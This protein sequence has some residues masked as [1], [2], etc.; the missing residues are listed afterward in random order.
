MRDWGKEKIEEAVKG[1]NTGIEKLVKQVEEMAED[2]AKA[3]DKG[4]VKLGM[5]F[6]ASVIAALKEQKTDF[7][8]N[9]LKK[10]ERLNFKVEATLVRKDPAT[11]TTG[12]VDAVGTNSIPFE[13]AS[14]EYGLTRIARRQPWLLQLANVSTTNKMYVQWA[15]QA[16]REGAANEVAEGT[17]KPQIDFDWVEKSAK[18]EKIAAYIKVSKEALDDLDGLQNEIETELR[19]AVLLKADTDLLSGDGTT[20]TINGLLN[21]DTAYSAGSFAGTVE[22]PNKS[23]VLRTAISQVITN[24]FQPNGILM[25]PADV[26]SM[27]L[28]K[29]S[30]GHYILPPFRSANG[31][32]ISG[33]RIYENTGMEIDKFVVGDFTKWNVRIREG[34]NIDIGHD[35]DDFTKNLVTI[36]AEMRLVSYVKTNHIGAFV[37]GDFSDAIAALSA[38]S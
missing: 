33:V 23:D 38:G 17:A 28:E 14:F 1:I 31:S 25:H 19:E 15:E 26:A 8:T 27:D 12:N 13:L 4:T 21:Q 35:M 36:L 16:N 9:P 22:N 5:S 10:G 18:V 32:T 6:G 34:V 7:A 24:F 30:D 11:F 3:K 20:P 37:S 2:V 29:A